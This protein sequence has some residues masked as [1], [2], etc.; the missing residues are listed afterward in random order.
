[1]TVTSVAIYNL[2]FSLQTIHFSTRFSPRHESTETPSPSTPFG[3]G[4]EAFR[5]HGP[6]LFNI[7]SATSTK[8]DLR[9]AFHKSRQSYLLQLRRG[10][11]YQINGAAS[12]VDTC[13]LHNDLRTP[14]TALPQPH[15]ASQSTFHSF[16]YRSNFK[17]WAAYKIL[18]YRQHLPA[19]VKN[20]RGQC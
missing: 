5:R 18:I 4:R 20:R 7:S 6:F 9:V 16:L 19:M 11:S 17:I 1:M 13:T 3:G 12:T 15:P 10:M 14:D 8:N 2:E